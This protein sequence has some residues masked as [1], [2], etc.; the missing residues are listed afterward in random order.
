MRQNMQKMSNKGMISIEL[1]HQLYIK[2]TWGSVLSK[3]VVRQVVFHD[4]VTR[5]SVGAQRASKKGSISMSFEVFDLVALLCK[6]LFAFKHW[7]VERVFLCMG[8]QVIEEV[9]PLSE[10]LFTTRVVANK[11]LNPSLSFSF[12]ILHKEEVFA[13]GNMGIKV[14]EVNVSTLS[15]FEYAKL[16]K[17]KS[18]F[19]SFFEIILKSFLNSYFRFRDYFFIHFYLTSNYYLCMFK[20]YSILLYFFI[21]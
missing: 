16:R 19:N 8:P 15:Y 20:N 14:R 6:S 2:L 17:P 18:P 7:A 13:T 4:W 5:E 9:I 21:L 11:W 1:R 3:L 12:L 10:Y